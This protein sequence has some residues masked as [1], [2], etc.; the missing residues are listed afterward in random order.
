MSKIQVDLNE[1]QEPDLQL[2]PPSRSV[3]YHVNRL[4][5][6]MAD[7]LEHFIRSHDLS[8]AQW[9]YLRHLYF[10]D[11][12]SQRELSDRVGR[13]GATTLSALKR[14]ERAGYVQIRKNDN[15]QRKNCV[16]LKPRGRKL[17]GELMPFV[18]KVEQ[19]AF[20]GLN[21][22]DIKRFWA[23]IIHMRSNLSGIRSNGWVLDDILPFE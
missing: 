15:D 20:Q 17:V 16:F 10:E 19:I 9:G 3:A 2:V 7:T 12:L 11:G 23:T 8:S 14:L 5:Q 1:E 13:H 6:E 18:G 21:D 4:H 22:E